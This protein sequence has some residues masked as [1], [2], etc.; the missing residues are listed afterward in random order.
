MSTP[1][2]IGGPPKVKRGDC[3]VWNQGFAVVESANY[4]KERVL[5]RFQNG[6]Q[7]QLMPSL[8]EVLVQDFRAWAEE[9]Q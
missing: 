9:T 7:G 2:L 5:A 3:F 6:L 4:E 8:V 1:A